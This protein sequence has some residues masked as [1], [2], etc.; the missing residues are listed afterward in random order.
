VIITVI[1]VVAGISFAGYLFFT[2]RG[3]MSATGT[4][5]D[6]GAVTRPVDLLA[7]R[8]LTDPAEEEFLRS[9]LRGEVFR[10]IERER[11]RAA[12][13][14]VERTAWNASVLLR[15]GEGL[16]HEE[17][18]LAALGRDLASAALRLRLNALLAMG[19]LRLRIWLPGVHIPVQ[20]LAHGYEELRD[21][22]AR[23][24]RA[25]RPSQVSHLLAAL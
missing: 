1:L 10:R 12:L 16:R 11:L 5:D 2:V 14:Y 13:E 22:F 8:N 15:M 3:S 20:Q 17:P 21:Q 25:Q 24:A 9:R 18:A 7:F 6:L 19:V 4:L 23:L